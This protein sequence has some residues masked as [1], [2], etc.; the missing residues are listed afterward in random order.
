MAGCHGAEGEDRI[1]KGVVRKEEGDGDRD[2]MPQY[3]SPSSLSRLS[4]AVPA[5]GRPS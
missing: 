5:P 3:I 2:I 1:K 4:L